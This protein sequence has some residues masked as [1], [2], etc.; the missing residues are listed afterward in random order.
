MGLGRGLCT[1]LREA[2]ETAEAPPVLCPRILALCCSIWAWCARRAALCASRPGT[3]GAW[4]ACEA[5]AAAGGGGGPARRKACWGWTLFGTGAAPKADEP[6]ALNGLEP[7]AAVP[8]VAAELSPNEPSLRTLGV[9]ALDWLLVVCTPKLPP[10]PKL[11][12]KLL[13][14]KLLSVVCWWWRPSPRRERPP[15]PSA[16]LLSSSR[17]LLLLWSC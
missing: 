8:A 4:P 14:P 5:A 16:I 10:V 7:T 11:P 12:P 9:M 1:L 13:P 15:L 6:R 17:G 3:W 2:A